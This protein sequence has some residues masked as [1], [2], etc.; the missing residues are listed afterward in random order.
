MTTI[1]DQIIKVETKIE[2]VEQQIATVEQKLGGGLSDVD[3]TYLRE[4]K[5]QLRE[6]K[7]QLRE[8]EKQLRDEKNLLL[9]RQQPQQDGELRCCSRIIVFI[10]LFEN[11]SLLLLARRRVARLVLLFQCLTPLFLYLI[12]RGSFSC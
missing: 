9:A 5:K 10:F 6:E 4:E 8:K 3:K 7:K 12:L 11:D 2:E 1:E